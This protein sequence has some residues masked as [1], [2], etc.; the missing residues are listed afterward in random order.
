M[1]TIALTALAAA[2]GLAT[3]SPVLNTSLSEYTVDTAGVATGTMVLDVS[4]YQSNDAQGSA[5]NQILSV[6]VGVGA[7]ITGIAWDVNMTS[8]GASWGSEMVLG[9]EGQINL[10]PSGD[11][12][13]V[14][15]VNYSSGVVDLSDNGLPNI[16][17]SAD[18]VLDIEFFETFV[19]NA[20]TGDNFFEAGSTVTIVGTGFVPTPGS[21]AVLGL[22]GLVAGRRRR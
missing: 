10:T 16:T 9:F 8:I 1:K 7:E 4:G 2:A 18:G 22:G 5:L 11:A 13:P 21:L 12:N 15:N 14:T 20:G 19:D 3:A 6:F 17:L